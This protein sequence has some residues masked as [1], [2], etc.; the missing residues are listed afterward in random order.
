MIVHPNKGLP[1]LFNLSLSTWIPWGGPQKVLLYAGGIRKSSK[2]RERNAL[3]P[4]T[5]PTILVSKLVTEPSSNK[6]I[7]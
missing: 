6:S 1:Y 7:G 2:R 3:N 5:L 4:N